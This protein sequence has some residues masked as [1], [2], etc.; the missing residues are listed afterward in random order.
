MRLINPSS[1]FNRRS[2][3]KTFL[4]VQGG[5]ENRY[6]GT[7]ATASAGIISKEAAQALSKSVES[8]SASSSEIDAAKKEERKKFILW[9]GIGLGVVIVGIATIIIIRQFRNQE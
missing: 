9:G 7:G 5:I 2:D 4:N 3:T 8:V 6:N 1:N